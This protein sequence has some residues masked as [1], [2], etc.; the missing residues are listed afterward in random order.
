[1]R[2]KHGRHVPMWEL[3][4]RTCRKDDPCNKNFSS[5]FGYLFERGD[6]TQFSEDQLIAI[7]QGM[8]DRPA[9][10]TPDLPTPIG[11]AIFGQFIDH[12]I[13]LDVITKLGEAFNDVE[14]LENIRT[15]RLEL[16]SIYLAGKEASPF[17]YE[18]DSDKMIIGTSDNLL[19]VQRNREGTAIIGD[20]RNDE[21]LFIS[22]MQSLFIRFHN[23]VVD[24]GHNFEEAQEFVRHTYQQIIVE[25]FLP[26]IISDDVLGPLMEG[27]E[28]GK[29]PS[30]YIN[31]SKVAHM[32][33]EFSAAAYRFGHSH[34]RQ[35]Y[36]VNDSLSGNL[37]DFGGFEA[38][39]IGK[40]VDWKFFFDL[41]G[42][43]FLKCRPIDTKLASALF[44]LPF[45]EV[46][47]KNLAKRN[48]VRGQLT[49]GLLSGEEVARRI[50]I[51]PLPK[52]HVIKKLGLKQTPL[53]FYILAEA[54]RNGGKLGKVGGTIV[55]GTLLQL[56]LQDKN[57]YINKNP[58][59]NPFDLIPKTKSIIAGVAK[60]VTDYPA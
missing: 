2:S 27:F 53:W 15:P 36:Q 7:A 13:T 49:F 32:P 29:L 48:L 52:H 6:D 37:F 33:V 16:D 55:G 8:I 41:D 60:A 59:F 21:N 3:I 14:Q 9:K 1:M 19:D 39:P 10:D 5:F 11:F 26:E 24:R 28:N 23:W 51:K 57:A 17:L 25:E 44:D 42:K 45:A 38:V 4:E 30:E 12:D 20:H 40:N 22:Q 58:D 50:G 31:W 34:V 43:S 18:K 47:L 54:E 35:N 46:G 56:L